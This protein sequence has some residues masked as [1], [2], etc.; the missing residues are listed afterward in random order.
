[1]SYLKKILYC[2][3]F[4]GMAQ[5]SSVANEILNPEITLI[6]NELHPTVKEDDYQQIINAI[7]SSEMLQTEL[8]ELIQTH[9]FTGFI[10]LPREQMK[11]YRKVMLFNGFT[12]SK[13]I[14]LTT[15]LLEEVRNRNWVDLRIEGDIVP[16]DTVF[17]I[18]H[19]LYHI[20]NPF[21]SKKYKTHDEFIEA[22]S[23]DEAKAFIVAWNS[24][25]L[26]AEKTNKKPLSIKQFSS[27]LWNARYRFVYSGAMKSK[28]QNKLQFSPRYMIELT[29]SNIISIVEKLSASSLADIE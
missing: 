9:Q 28:T 17:I 13:K 6:L 25:L 1:M 4:I 11:K 27:L 15:E 26:S 21:D 24:M 10:V 7:L 22:I 3:L 8:S 20:K 5:T 12:E 19:L 2:I 29:D 23:Q 18:S 16:N 14:I